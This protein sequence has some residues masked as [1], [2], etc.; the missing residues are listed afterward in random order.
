MNPNSEEFIQPSFGLDG[1]VRCCEGLDITVAVLCRGC[2]VILSSE[3][4]YCY[5]KQRKYLFNLVS[6]ASDRNADVEEQRGQ[7]DT[8]Q[9]QTQHKANVSTS[10]AARIG[11]VECKC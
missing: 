6:T 1:L 8:R 4:I 7:R 2:P 10:D 5:T 11:R 3:R 9:T